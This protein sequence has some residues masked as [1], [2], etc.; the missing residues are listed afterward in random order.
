MSTWDEKD[1]V[2]DTG[3]RFDEKHHSAPE[4]ILTATRDFT[5]ETPV[6]IDTELAEMFNEQWQHRMKA[7]S[8]RGSAE[9]YQRML[10]RMDKFDLGIYGERYEGNIERRLDEAEDHERQA[11]ELGEKMLPF[12]AEFT[13]RGGWSRAFLVTGGHLHSS[14]NCSTCNREGKRTQF[15]WMTD[16]SGSDEGDIVSDAGKRACTTCYPSAPVDTLGQPSKMFTPDEE[17]AARQR[18]EREAEKA[19]KAAVKEAKAIY[20]PDG[21]PLRAPG[22]YGQEARTL[23]T[24]ERELTDALL[25]AIHRERPNSNINQEYLDE[26]RLWSEQLIVAIAAK[27]DISEDE[28]R[29]TGMKK[30]E[31]KYKREWG[32]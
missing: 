29:A 9:N 17:E 5:T 21:T 32:G 31:A 25:L 30:A 2:R 23:V 6:D 16:Y 1:V 20:N 24:A 10:D 3:G 7:D 4:T 26:Q 15:A 11:D 14:M 28:A 12:E 13:R 19:R 22:R 8:A 18:A 27:K